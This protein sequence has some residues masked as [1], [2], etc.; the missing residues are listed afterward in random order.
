M[1]LCKKV[2]AQKGYGSKTIIQVITLQTFKI[3]ILTIKEVIHSLGC[4]IWNSGD[5]YLKRI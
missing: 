2:M 4:L 3:A 1:P 5:T